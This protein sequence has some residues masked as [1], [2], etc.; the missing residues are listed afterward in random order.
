MLLVISFT[1]TCISLRVNGL[2]SY[3]V[4]CTHQRELLTP[5]EDSAPE[6]LELPHFS[7]YLKQM[8]LF[9]YIAEF[10]LILL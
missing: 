8:E 1:F 10:I 9:H 6:L 4:Q 3:K 2:Q 5:T 7:V